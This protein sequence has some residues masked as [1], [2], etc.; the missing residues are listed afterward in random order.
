METKKSV[1]K[2]VTD[3][4]I[5]QLEKGVV[6]WRKTWNFN[7]DGFKNIRGNEYSGVNVLLLSMSTLSKG[8]R[9]PAYSGAKLPPIPEQSCHHS[10]P[11]LPPIPVG[12]LPL[13]RLFPGIN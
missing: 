4:I 11:K 13:F 8:Y 10:G 12:K 2:I 5:D 6:P 3:K 1:Y 9:S 7:G